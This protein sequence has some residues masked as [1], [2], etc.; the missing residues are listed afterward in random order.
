[1][2][3]VLHLVNIIFNNVDTCNLFK[4]TDCN[5]VTT[6]STGTALLTI[7]LVGCSQHVNIVQ[8]CV[9][10]TPH[11]ESAFYQNAYYALNFYVFTSKF[12]IRDVRSLL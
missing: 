3:H 10:V 4:L 7:I 5:V 6:C 2:L 9:K 12:G 11:D 1:M 8:S